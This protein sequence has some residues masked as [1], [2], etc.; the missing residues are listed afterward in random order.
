MESEPRPF[1]AEEPMNGNEE[2]P[3][4]EDPGSE[5]GPPKGRG[6]RAP[7]SVTDEADDTSSQPLDA[8]V[9]SLGR[10]A[11]YPHPAGDVEVLHTHVSVVFLAGEF[12]Y[13]IKKAVDLGFLDFTTL[14]RR[15]HFC[16]EEVRLNRRLAPDVYLG[17]VP[18]T[19]ADGPEADRN[20]S[21]R[22]SGR[23]GPPP[24]FRIGGDGGAVEYAVKM[25]RLTP[26]D[27]L[28]ERL[29]R[30]DLDERTVERV[31]VRIA[32]F[33]QEARG[34][35]EV[36]AWGR[37]RVVARNVLENL[38]QTREHVGRTVSEAVHR[39]AREVTE[40]GLRSNRR[41]IEDRRRREVP[42]DTH[43]DLHLDHVYLLP[44]RDPPD[45]L[46]VID[47]IEFNRRFRY[48]D[49][50]ADLAFLA[51][52]LAYRGRRDLAATLIDGYFDRRPDP[53]GRSLLPL[54]V[55]YRALVRAKVR[56]IAAL[57]SS[58]PM[59]ERRKA[60]R[61]ARGYW[62]LGLDAL[63]DPAERPGLVLIGGL[64]GTGKSTLARG[65]AR[66]GDFVVVSSDI[67]RKRL[68]GLGE[69]EAA[70]E[71]GRGIY[72]PT[73]TRR[74]Y[75]ACLRK[76]SRH[77]CEGR[78]VVVDATFRDDGWRRR[79]MDRAR[80]LAVRHVFLVARCDPRI[81]RARIR[82]RGPDPSDADWQIHREVA[83]R[84]E[85]ISGGVA[86]HTVEVETGKG[87]EPAVRDAMEA[88]R[89]VGLA[90]PSAA[91]RG[92]APPSPDGIP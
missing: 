87:P 30:G 34:G 64:P 44:D 46:V 33:H 42:R 88:L 47:C 77:L 11:A 15:R 4:T 9:R 8:L 23:P 38:R 39:R 75:A 71:F 58:V 70:A 63:S 72:T 2:D 62:L 59:K 43:G 19:N 92:G 67:E 90:A 29:R 89:H 26:E 6:H 74:T 48:A 14:D 16:R 18:I 7:E 20:G 68:A 66:A 76:A 45:D 69:E 1:L 12:A 41:R 32:D 53:G 54:Y 51:M 82:D 25:R 36:A 10:E 79:F 78:R 49:P 5:D 28:L 65:L 17:V 27:T 86:R 61:D 60:A 24:A 13:K 57:E 52:D 3:M 84:W 21:G 73:W 31:A 55:S 56:G 50:V 37:W 85:P 40:A 83:E 80:D 35:P 22:P 91:R 81:A